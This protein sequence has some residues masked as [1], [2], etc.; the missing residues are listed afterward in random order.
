[1][2]GAGSQRVWFPAV[3]AGLAGVALTAVLFRMPPGP[4]ASGA[5]A[6]PRPPLG[7]AGTA[8]EG[9]RQATELFDPT[10][11]F[12]PT[13]WNS[14][15]K[16]AP[17]PE[18]DPMRAYPPKLSGEL[19][20]G[21]PGAAGVPE[22]PEDLLSSDPAGRPFRGFGRTRD[23]SPALPARRALVEITAVGTGLLVRR[24][25]VEDA[26]P[27]AAPGGWWRPP[28]FLAAVDSAGLVGPL[29]LTAGSGAENVDD[30][31][32]SYLEESL[33]VGDRLRPGIYR[34]C[35]GP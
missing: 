19:P 24:L 26:A 8:N 15:Q 27:P 34:I 4:S 10:P 9:I 18:P 31:F 16:A 1:M 25:S 23:A 22:R 20:L 30:Y 5:W 35:V 11:L 3:A 21:F 13:R 28:E 2:S 33:R 6:P 17:R 29:V 7:L 12:L 14:T 32:R